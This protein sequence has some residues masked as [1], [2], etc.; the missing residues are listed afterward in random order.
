MNNADWATGSIVIRLQSLCDGGRRGLYR[1][2]R[3]MCDSRRWPVGHILM[4]MSGTGWPACQLWA[5]HQQPL[6]LRHSFAHSH[7]ARINGHPSC[8]SVSNDAVHDITCS[9][10]SVVG[11]R[12]WRR[13]DDRHSSSGM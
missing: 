3:V 7:Q 10:N 9:G 2:S 5:L 4:I 1:H 6:L 11:N 8:S 13:G 12:N